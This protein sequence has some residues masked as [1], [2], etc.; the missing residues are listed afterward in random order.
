MASW[1]SRTLIG[2]AAAAVVAGGLTVA[3]LA[4]AADEPA[5]P[6]LAFTFNGYRAGDFTVEDPEYVTTTFQ[7]AD[8]VLDS[9]V[10][11]GRLTVFAAGAFD[12]NSAVT[13]YHSPHTFGEGTAVTVNGRP[14]LQLTF[15]DVRQGSEGPFDV[16][17][18]V[19]AW[20]YADNAWASAQTRDPY[21]S[22]RQM[23]TAEL[24]AVAEKFRLKSRPTAV[25]I[26]Y[27]AGFLP[28]GYT[29][30]A[31]SAQHFKVYSQD[32]GADYEPEWSEAAFIY[33]AAPLRP[34]AATGSRYTDFADVTTP[35]LEITV[36]PVDTYV[37]PGA[38]PFDGPCNSA[39]Y[40]RMDLRDGVSRG[41]VYD[42]T[43]TLSREDTIRVLDGLRWVANPQNER[44][45]HRAR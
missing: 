33:S 28:A 16:P 30:Q 17:V 24:V 32:P 39:N 42:P 22:D 38:L 7:S 6:T 40:C 5:A 9:Q 34:V 13:G 19:L 2:A 36:G 15:T 8:I 45:W 3:S 44:S 31:V 18:T 21:F 43:R 11:H 4:S 12:R 26:P 10:D 25:R 37:P 35:H 41:F 23:T 1:L 29:L 20:E 14:G 27:R